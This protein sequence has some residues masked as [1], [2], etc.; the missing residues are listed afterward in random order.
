M[1]DVGSTVA[2]ALGRRR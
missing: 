1:A 2:W